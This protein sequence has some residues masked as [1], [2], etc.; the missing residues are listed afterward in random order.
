VHAILA[1]VVGLALGG[2]V[3]G[4]SYFYQKRLMKEAQALVPGGLQ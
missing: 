4:V 3:F 2:A 1:A